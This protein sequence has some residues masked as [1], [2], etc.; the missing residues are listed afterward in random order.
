MSGEAPKTNLAES[1]PTLKD[2]DWKYTDLSRPIEI[3]Q[4]WLNAGSL[5]QAPDASQIDEI[6]ASTD[7]AWIVIAN[8]RLLEDVST[9]LAEPGVDVSALGSDAPTIEVPLANLNAQLRT[10]AVRIRITEDRLAERPIGLL[11]VDR[12]LGSPVMS[13]AR[14]DIDVDERAA[15]RFIEYHASSGDDEHYSNSLIRLTLADE[16]S[17]EYL[18]FQDRAL[19]HSQTARLNVHLGRDSRF[20]HCGIDLGNRLARNDLQ[21]DIAAPGADATF[22]G[23]YVAGNG[24]HVDN[25]T[26][27]DHRVGPAVSNQE[28]RGVLAGRC[29]AVWNGKAIVHI[30]ADGTDAQQA[31][32]NLLLSEHGEID[33]KPELEIYADEVKCAHGTTV[34]QLDERALFYLRSRGLDEARAK[35]VLT[36][37]FAATVVEHAP[38]A[39]LHEFIGDRVESRL[40]ELGETS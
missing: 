17:V 25:H 37:A 26:R 3:G 31:N 19:H 39:E 7:A 18:R 35:R 23:L 24:Q 21:V 28:Y 29:R 27:V 20:T 36:R 16:A 9:G 1:F 13:Q 38:I 40:R 14:I 8:G 34:G 30:G 6:K 11:I 32:H 12:A 2:E 22:N 4:D 15:A 10:D 5:E 33:A